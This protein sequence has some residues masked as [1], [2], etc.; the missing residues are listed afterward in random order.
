[1]N[2]PGNFDKLRDFQWDQGITRSFR[3]HAS[4]VAIW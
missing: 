3:R 4:I 2:E 1:M